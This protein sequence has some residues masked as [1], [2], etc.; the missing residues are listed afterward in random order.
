[1]ICS[2]WQKKIVREQTETAGSVGIAVHLNF[3]QT[4]VLEVPQRCLFPIERRKESRSGILQIPLIQ[5]QVCLGLRKDWS[6]KRW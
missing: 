4:S 3:L 6:Q 2:V 5:I 1:M